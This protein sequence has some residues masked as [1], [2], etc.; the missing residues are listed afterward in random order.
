LLLDT[1]AKK[2]A[3]EKPVNKTIKKQLIL[4]TNRKLPADQYYLTKSGKN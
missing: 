1:A 2:Q 4:T 3:T